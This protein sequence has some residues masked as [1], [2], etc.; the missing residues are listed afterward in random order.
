MRLYF[1][2]IGVHEFVR[3]Q[4]H[5]GEPFDRVNHAMRSLAAAGLIAL[6]REEPARAAPNLMRHIYAT[7]YRGWDRLVAALEAIADAPVGGADA[8]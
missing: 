1:R 3:E 8:R 6:E 4:E 2:S 5:L 7:R